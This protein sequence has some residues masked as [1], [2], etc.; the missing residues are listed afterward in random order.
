MRSK[1]TLL[2]GIVS[3]LIGLAAA[4]GQ[5]GGVPGGGKAETRRHSEGRRP[6]GEEGMRSGLR[7]ALGL[8]EDQV[9]AITQEEKSYHTALGQMREQVEQLEKQ[10][11]ELAAM[12]DAEAV[13]RVVI[14][15]IAVQKQME[16]EE[17]ALRQRIN[18]ILTPQQQDKL[19][20]LME[21]REVRHSEAPLLFEIPHRRPHEIDEPK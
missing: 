5:T 3:L 21:V 15:R 20:Q 14:Q 12:G 10:T 1:T 11:F 16:T 17:S 7:E 13:G 9:A 4:F 19:K 18:D 8:T 2:V 6:H